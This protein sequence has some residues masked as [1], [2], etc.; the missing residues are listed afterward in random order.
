MTFSGANPLTLAGAISGFGGM[1]VN[2]T[3]SMAYTAST[4]NTYTGTTTISAGTLLFSKPAGA[5]V[6]GPVVIG[7]GGTL[8][9]TTNVAQLSNSATTVGQDMT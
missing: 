4:A 9:Q 7:S 5:A 8:Q 2:S 6:S 3:S 1:T